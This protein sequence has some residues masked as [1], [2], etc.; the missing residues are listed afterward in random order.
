MKERPILFNDEMVRALL[1]GRKT[2]TRRL[3]K[4]QPAGD[5]Q[6]NDCRAAKVAGG[7][8]WQHRG[9][10]SKVFTCPY[11]KS[12]DQ[13]WVRET[14][15]AL[16][17]DPPGTP[18]GR[19]PQP[20]DDIRYRADPGQDWQWRDGSLPW[21]PSIHMPRWACRILL[22]VT[23]VRV[24]RLQDITEDDARAEGCDNSSTE[25]AHECGW[26]EKPRRAFRRVWEQI[27]GS[28]SWDANPWV[29]VIEFRRI[30]QQQ[31]ADAA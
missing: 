14:W 27:N 17:T 5:T 24:E 15:G 23:A 19:K 8:Q 11:G 16:F 31:E 10:A 9:G 29:W 22:E 6:G 30:D 1:D 2:Q 3:V 21:R 7:F 4:N 12:G 20:G 18:G 13:L 25:A 28:D 26:Y